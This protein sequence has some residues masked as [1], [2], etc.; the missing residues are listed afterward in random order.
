MVR[1]VDH[2]KWLG[3]PSVVLGELWCGFLLGSRVQQNRVD[4]DRFLSHP[5]V[6]EI[7]IDREIGEIYGD[8]AV[9]LRRAG[10]T[11]PVNDI[12]IAAAAARTGTI[13]LTYDPHFRAI[14]R[15]ASIVLPAPIWNR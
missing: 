5:F 12:W 1:L 7:L 13:V 14:Q 3:M 4:L 11:V 6:Q 8:I 2:A 10:K 15:A 9:S